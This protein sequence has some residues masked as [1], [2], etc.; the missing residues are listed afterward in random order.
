MHTAKI[1]N[2]FFAITLAFP[3]I[4]RAAIPASV[5]EA[6]SY[7][8]VADAVAYHTPN[9]SHKSVICRGR[10]TP[11]D[12]GGGNFIVVRSNASTNLGTI[13][14]MALGGEY[15]LVRDYSGAI[16]VKWFGAVGD[17]KTADQVAIQ[18]SADFAQTLVTGSYDTPRPVLFFPSSAGYRITSAVTVGTNVNVRM[19]SP[20][21]AA[22]TNVAA[23]TIGTPGYYSMNTEYHISIRRETV[24]DWSNES[25]IGVRFYGLS[26]A[27][28]YLDDIQNFTIGAQFMA[29]A[30]GIAYNWIRLG[31]LYNSKIKLDCSNKNEGFFN[32][33]QIEGGRVTD[34]ATA[35]LTKSRYGIRITST[36]GKYKNNN[37]NVIRDV[38]FEMRGNLLKNGAEAIPWLVEHGAENRLEGAWR[39]EGNGTFVA[40]FKNGSRR[41]LVFMA[42][43]TD[44]DTAGGS[45]IDNQSDYGGNMAVGRPY[46]NYIHTALPNHKI[47]D[48]GPLYRNVLRTS[49]TNTFSVANVHFASSSN[50][51]IVSTASGLRVA[52]D[53]V[54]LPSH[55]G[56]GV[57]VDTEMCKH[58]LAL[59]DVVTGTGGQWVV[60]CYDASGKVL[61]NPAAGRHAKSTVGLADTT[62]WGGAAR[63]G[64]VGDAPLEF[65]FS[66]AVKRVALIT[67]GGNTNCSIRSFSFY[68]LDGRPA[69]AWS[70]FYPVDTGIQMNAAPSEKGRAI[71]QFVWNDGANPPLGWKWDGKTWREYGGPSAS[72]ETNYSVYAAGAAPALAAESALLKFGT[73]SPSLRIK[74]PGTY[75]IQANVGLK[76]SGAIFEAN[77][78]ATVKLRK[79]NETLADLPNST[80]KVTLDV[81]RSAKTASIGVF[82]LPPVIYTAASNDVIEAWGE[83]SAAPGAGKIEAESA[84]IIAVRI[85]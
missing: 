64:D 49:G 16:N 84:E 77:Q 36:D 21:V 22:T 81:V 11:G 42:G 85:P 38:C 7:D 5:G 70:G 55:I 76:Y 27:P 23:L 35:N 24:S 74:N 17:A 83:L 60:R 75:L 68:S 8:T 12:G 56:L 62:S 19:D 59:R 4:P 25:D 13:F 51:N 67:S 80:R 61:A 65:E 72:A 69:T 66:D 54:D 52:D 45:D 57:L 71:G 3:L 63:T 47:F 58:I 10:L 18:A 33:N 46:I 31:S 39:S 6:M 40:R 30:Q 1:W 14:P 82:A 73:T 48:S 34:D 50:S 2:L 20:I 79:R 32:Q 78:V 26:R 9:E 44:S 43:Y 37:A 29:D 41:N 53:R 28:I 15:R